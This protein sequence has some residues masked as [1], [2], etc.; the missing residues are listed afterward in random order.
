M[1]WQRWKR[2]RY[3]RASDESRIRVF[4]AASRTAGRLLL[5]RNAKGPQVTCPID[6]K[7][8]RRAGATVRLHFYTE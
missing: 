4:L 3:P 2:P 6:M 1:S 8:L 5:R 7:E